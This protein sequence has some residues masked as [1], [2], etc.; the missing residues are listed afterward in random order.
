MKLYAVSD[1]HLGCEENRRAL[2]ALPPSLDDWLI[3]AGDVGEG[4]KHMEFAFETLSRRFCQILWVPGNHELW[5][6]P[7]AGNGAR[8]QF[9]YE[10]LVALCRAYGVLTPE[11]P[12]PIA[13]FG[14]TTSIPR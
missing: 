9:K 2:C 8:G 4:A 5:T 14:Q 1:L 11:D 12:Y 6:I 7:S 3:L 10:Q 13:T